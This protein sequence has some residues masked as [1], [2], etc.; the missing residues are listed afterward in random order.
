MQK[1]NV[2]FLGENLCLT[3]LL[4]FRYDI[5]AEAGQKQQKY[6][7]P[8]SKGAKRYRCILKEI[9]SEGLI[10]GLGLEIL[11]V[12]VRKFLFAANVI[13]ELCSM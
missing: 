6:S 3:E 2:Y 7:C 9:T 11:P 4:V 13:A 10:N 12:R 5:A 1:W 8:H